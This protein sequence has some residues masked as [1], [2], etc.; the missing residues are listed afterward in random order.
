MKLIVSDFDG[1]FF[2]KNYD[3]NIKLINKYDIDFVIATGR[4]FKS[5]KKD[6]KIKCKYYICNDGGYILDSDNTIIYKNYID[7]NTINILYDRMIEL[8]YTDYFFDNINEFS[9]KKIN[10][11]NKLSIKIKDNNYNEDMKYIINGLKDIY[12]YISTNWINIISIES[13]KENA[14]EFISKLN[15]YDKIIVVGNEI[16]DYEMIKKYKGFLVSDKN[17]NNFKT[18]KKFSEIENIIKNDQF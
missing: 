13:K 4:N 3:E 17:I 16:N 5:L 10:N 14:I 18:I 8:G 9:Q 6:L 7:K 15:D 1:T 11:I 12:A 2:D